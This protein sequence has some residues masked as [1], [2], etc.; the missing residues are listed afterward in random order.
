MFSFEF[1][2]IFKS[3]YFKEHLRTAGSKTPARVFLLN[4]VAS[5][6][7]WMRLTVLEKDSITGVFV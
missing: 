3:I 6:T 1:C 4:K 2:E 7:G 5:L